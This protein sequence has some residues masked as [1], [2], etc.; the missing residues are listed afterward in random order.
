MP[1]VLFLLGFFIASV[2]MLLL[3]ASCTKKL[4]ISLIVSGLLLVLLVST[5]MIM[6]GVAKAL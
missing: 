3:Y 6:P 2:G 1:S 5:V 4:A